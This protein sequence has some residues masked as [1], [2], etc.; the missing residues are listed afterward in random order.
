MPLKPGSVESPDMYLGTQ[1]KCMQL[2]NGTWAWS[3]SPSK[4]VQKAVR[5]CNEYVAKCL[6]K[7]HKL[8]KRAYNPFESCYC[9]EMDVSLVLEQGEVSYYHSL[10]GV[11]RWM[12]EIG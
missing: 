7:G 10:I 5:I 2:Y 1:L 9:P 4:Y 8:P 11:M 6:S 3:M 12:I